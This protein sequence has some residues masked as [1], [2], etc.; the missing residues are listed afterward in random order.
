MP[1]AGEMSTTW[2]KKTHEEI[3]SSRDSRIIGATE[4]RLSGR[5][6]HEAV[7]LISQS[8]RQLRYV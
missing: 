7:P 6:G 1:I 2:Q 4:H 5:A 3:K 8:A